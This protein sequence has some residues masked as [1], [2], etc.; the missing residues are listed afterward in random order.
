MSTAPP[1]SAAETGWPTRLARLAV[2]VALVLLVLAVYGQMAGVLLPFGDAEKFEFIHLDDGDYVTSNP[3]V[4]RGLTWEGIYWAFTANHSANWHPLTWIS[5]M[6]DVEMFGFDP[7]GYHLLN[8]LWHLANVLLLFTVLRRMTGRFW[9][10]AMVAALFAVHPLHV[11]SVAW[12][13]ERK[14]VLSTFFGLLAL[15]AYEAYA[16]RGGW[17]R[18]GLVLGAY[19]LSLLCKQMWVTLPFALLLLDYWPLERCPLSRSG[20]EATSGGARYPRRGWWQ[21]GLEKLPL[22]ALAAASSAIVYLVQRQYGAMSNFELVGPGLRLQNAIVSYV[23][24]LEKTFWPR[25]L[26]ILYP[27]P[28]EDYSLVR[29]SICAGVLVLITGIALVNWRRRPWLA[30]GWLWYLGT[31]VPVI[32]LVQVGGQAW[33]DRYAYLP[34]I[35]LFVMLVWS[36]A[37]LVDAASRRGWGLAARI[38]ASAVA[39]IVLIP[40]TIWGH[41]QVGYWRN[42]EHLF[43]HTLDVASPNYV[44]CTN[45]AS[46]YDAHDRVDDARK[47]FREAL[48]IN[49]NGVDALTRCG[50]CIAQHMED[51]SEA[52]ALYR[53][54]MQIDPN[55]TE[56]MIHLALLLTDEGKVDEALPL[57]ERALKGT[58]HRLLAYAALGV[59]YARRGDRD[60]ALAAFNEG[61]KIDRHDFTIN[62]AVADMYVG[63]RE[64]QNALPHYELVLRL[65]PDDAQTHTDYGTALAQL[66]RM[67]EALAHFEEAVRVRP[68][69]A[70]GR[71]KLGKALAAQGKIARGLEQLEEAVRLRPDWA[72][73]LND[74]AWILATDGVARNRNGPKAVDYAER[75]CRITK[76]ADPTMLDTLAAAYAETGLWNAAVSTG[77]EAAALALK[78]GNKAMADEIG[79]R[80]GL[81]QRRQPYHAAAGPPGSP[82]ET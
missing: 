17:L 77:Q 27:H 6:L 61:L 44:I 38:A 8:A 39:A 42:T 74:I 51:K 28:L 80:V 75:A 9:P 72:P 2:W 81:Y 47:R 5:L 35:G 15:L 33:A 43:V 30:V 78:L 1:I 19:C 29:I 34:H 64:P 45:L 71:L 31:L 60:K 36:A 48:E 11:E 37:G 69:Y 50:H 3:W 23:K 13:S 40:L 62:N 55:N 54:A 24:Y 20:D 82:G 52:K 63:M 59:A 79:A 4:K 25:D 14:D 76:R 32:G 16:R 22:M 7:T 73:P 67:E 56:P 46:Y 49:P 12:V 57:L 10:S 58:R 18:Y 65:A 70:D 41:E 68:G 21:L 53:R 66:G 26:G